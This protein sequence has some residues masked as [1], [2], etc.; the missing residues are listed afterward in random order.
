MTDSYGTIEDEIFE[1]ISG[2]VDVNGPVQRSVTLPRRKYRKLLSRARSTELGR[3]FVK[4][5]FKFCQLDVLCGGIEILV[6]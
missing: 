6:S 4:C 3:Q 2:F 5:G 1:A